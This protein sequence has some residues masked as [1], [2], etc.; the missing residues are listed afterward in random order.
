MAEDRMQNL[1]G[2]TV[3]LLGAYVSNNTL[4]S[5]DLSKLI[6]STH[7]ALAK[8]DAPVEEPAAAPEYTPAVSI[9]KSL[10]SPQHII[11]LIDGKPYKTLKRH[12]AKHGLTFAEYR[13]RYKLPANYPAVS[14]AYSEH[15]RAVATELGLGRRN[16]STEAPP[17]SP[18]EGKAPAPVEARKAAATKPAVSEN[19][20]A[21][22]PERPAAD[23]KPARKSAG[24]KSAGSAPKVAKAEAASPPTATV[25]KPV[26]ATA[27]PRRRLKQTP[28]ADA[29]EGEKPAKTGGRRSTKGKNGS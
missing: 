3:E 4:A 26:K 11:S 18:D 14:P 12:L 2:L 29:A 1:T 17:Q 20:D 15:R 13:E 10:A 27:A 9:R 22:A 6:A 21:A 7:A 24:R 28:K 23:Q 8:L 16:Q 25:E 19:A 5:E